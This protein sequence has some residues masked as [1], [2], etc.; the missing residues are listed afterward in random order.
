MFKFA[1]CCATVGL[2]SGCSVIP[3]SIV[4][5]GENTFQIYQVHSE[6]GATANR[7]VFGDI[8]ECT[9][10][11]VFI[12]ASVDPSM[13]DGKKISIMNPQIIGSYSYRNQAGT[14]RTLPIIGLSKEPSP[15]GLS[16]QP[17]SQN[18]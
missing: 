4:T 7:C 16:V 11:F 18:N 3:Q 14:T 8:M 15:K 9:G 1:V 10:P 2:L 13:Y 5:E 17:Y 6:R 12:D